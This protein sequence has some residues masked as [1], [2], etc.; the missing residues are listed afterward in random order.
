M[1]FTRH[2][3]DDREAYY[4]YTHYYSHKE[5]YDLLQKYKVHCEETAEKMIKK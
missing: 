1:P 4:Q 5:T 2:S 3:K